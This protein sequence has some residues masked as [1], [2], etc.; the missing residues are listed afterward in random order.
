LLPLLLPLLLPPLLPLLLVVGVVGTAWGGPT[1]LLHLLL[2]R[3]LLLLLLPARTAGL[4]GRCLP[5]V[6]H[7]Q[8]SAKCCSTVQCSAVQCRAGPGVSATRQ[9]T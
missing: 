9:L 4:G 5:Q 1:L 7:L 6:M 3:C 8:Y 2:R